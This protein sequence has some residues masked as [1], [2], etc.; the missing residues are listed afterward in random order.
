MYL[1]WNFRPYVSNPYYKLV[2]EEDVVEM[3]TLMVESETL[4]NRNVAD[5]DIDNTLA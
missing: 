4:R 1:G 3:E 5:E 2:D